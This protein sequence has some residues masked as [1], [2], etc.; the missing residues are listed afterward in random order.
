MV[1]Q[2]ISII[3]CSDSK[4]LVANKAIGVEVGHVTKGDFVAIAFGV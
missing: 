3:S 4:I 2:I 1:D